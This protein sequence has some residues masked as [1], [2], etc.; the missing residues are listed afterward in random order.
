MNVAPINITNFLQ[1]PTTELSHFLAGDNQLVICNG[2]NPSYKKGVLYKDT[3]YVQIGDALQANKP[4]RSLHHSRR[5][6]AVSEMLA[7]VDNATSD[8]TQ[9]FYYSGLAWVE[10]TDA[11]TAW[12]NF[13]GIDVEMEEFIAN[14]F[15]VGYGATDG[16]LPVRTLTGSGHTF[17]TTL[18]TDMPRA[19][20]IKRFRDRLYVA[21]CNISGTNYPYRVYF[22]SVPSAG[23]ITWTPA[24]DFLD[25]DFSEDITGINENWDRLMIFTEFSAYM[26]DQ[27][28][29]KKVWDVGCGQHRTLKN[30]GAYML[31]VNKDNVYAST[32][33]RPAPI[34][35]DILELLRQ[36]TSSNW[37]AEVVDNEYHL[38]IGATSANGL[39]YT[40]CLLS[41]NVDNGMWRWRELYDGLNSLARYTTGGDDYLWLGCADGEVMKKT[42]HYETTP[43]YSDDGNPILSHFRTK[44]YDFG[45]PTVLKKIVRLMAYAEYGQCLVLGYRIFD[46]NQE[47]IQKFKS[48]GALNHVITTFNKGISGYFIQFEGREFSTNQAWR[49]HGFSAILGPDN[50]NL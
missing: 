2:A 47:A 11:E 44:A 15:F 34:G 22:S 13:A 10:I 1:P 5:T 9:L 32:G 6:S 21:N 19:K 28:T 49:F 43:V 26:Y 18:T 36:S 27:D 3:G 35:N 12:A 37:R 24:S 20:Y 48:I 30:V 50:T 25:V 38:Y 7:T 29:W 16:F 45:D 42:K 23:A 31:W 14:T 39:F 4:I 41:Y 8:D 17:G 46:K 33:G 40:N